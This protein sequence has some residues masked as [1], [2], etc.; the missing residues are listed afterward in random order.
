MLL[1]DKRKK[2]N[3]P[4]LDKSHRFELLNA[5]YEDNRVKDHRTGK[6]H[7]RKNVIYR[8]PAVYTKYNK[9][10]NQN[11]EYRYAVHEIS[12][13]TGKDEGTTRYT[14]DKITFTSSTLVVGVDQP[15]LYEFLKNSPW[16][17][18]G[19]NRT[20]IFRELDPVRDS[21]TRLKKEALKNKAKY[22][23]LNEGSL[24]EITLRRILSALGDSTDHDINIVKDKLLDVAE[25]DPK[26]F[27][28]MIGSKETEFKSLI[29]ELIEKK[30]ISLNPSKRQWEWGSAS[31]K[32]A[33]NAICDCP[34]GKDA[35]DWLIDTLLRE[36]ALLKSFKI[37]QNHKPEDPK[38][39]ESRKELED[40]AKK[41][42]CAQGVALMSD[43]TL[44][45][46]VSET[47]DAYKKEYEDPST[48]PA[49]RAKVEK[50]LVEAGELIKT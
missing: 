42:K 49:R 38:K 19:I 5:S 16:I 24:P 23:I 17:E 18:N 36:D 4:K 48:P 41:L 30:M 12:V 45:A 34:Q 44:A 20:P 46:K 10:I 6:K 43:D 40:K 22:L 7:I 35:T 29:S 32:D 37:L 47:A 14:P 39:T 3:L 8:I 27:M 11:E 25:K 1:V 9:A 21:E 15:D 28:D 31:G 33:G 2:E 13:K 50:I 26:K